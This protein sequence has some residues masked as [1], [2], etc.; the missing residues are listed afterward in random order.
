MTPKGKT[1]TA[2]KLENLSK[3]LIKFKETE[4]EISK[5]KMTRNAPPKGDN[6]RGKKATTN[7]SNSGANTTEIT[8]RSR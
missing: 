2:T 7:E 8:A 6:T 3:E 5:D 1:T 4:N